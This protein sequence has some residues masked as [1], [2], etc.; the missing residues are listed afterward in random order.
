EAD[1]VL[2]DV[3]GLQEE[4]LGERHPNTLTTIH[5]L[6]LVK[7]ATGDL[8]NAE[9]LL[10]REVRLRSQDNPYS[11]GARTSLSGLAFFYLNQGKFAEAIPY[12]EQAA[13]AY[14][15][16]TH[17]ESNAVIALTMLGLCRNKIGEHEQAKTNL[18]T[19]ERICDETLQ[20][21]WLQYVV[22]SLLGEVNLELGDRIGAEDK[23]LTGYDG[24]KV[25]EHELPTRWKPLG[26][27]AAT[28]RLVQFYESSGDAEQRSRA[29]QYR[30]E[31]EALRS[32]NPLSNANGQ[33]RN[34]EDG[35]SN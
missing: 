30:A 7:Q 1:L 3:L 2:S 14:Q 23:L 8:E 24:L 32:A 6:A 17:E 19:A 5:N 18:L 15:K 20:D 22:S 11:L 27:R 21:H 26:L 25:H 33:I 35:N 28:R 9:L 34:V 29:E 10:Q 4:S 16:A 12:Y 13:V 31:L